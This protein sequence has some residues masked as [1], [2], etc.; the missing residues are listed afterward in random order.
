MTL[1]L[2][3]Y[4]LPADLSLSG[5]LAVDTETLGLLTRRD[6]L[7]LVQLADGEGAVHLVHFPTP[8]YAAPQL[9][10]LLADSHRCKLMHYARFDMAA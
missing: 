6:R 2:H 3:R 8:D 7:C 9:K 1:H 10:A 5:D 4:D